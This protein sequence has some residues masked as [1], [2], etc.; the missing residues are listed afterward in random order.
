MKGTLKFVVA[1]AVT[2][3]VMLVFRALV[4]TIYT[5]PSSGLKPELN[6]GDRILVN[7]W[8]YGLRTGLGGLFDYGRLCKGNVEYGD[9]VAFNNPL[10][11]LH[12]ISKRSIFVGYCKAMP[13]D[14]VHF[15]S[16]PE[17][18]IPGKSHM[19][20]VT[21]DNMQLLCNTYIIHEHKDAK[22]KNNNLYVDGKETHCASFTQNYYWM[23]THSNQNLKDSRFFGLV[24]ESHIIGRVVAIVYNKDD[25][26]PFYE[27]YRED[28]LF[29]FI[30]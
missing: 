24:P 6:D 18:I 9:L 1:L 4:F 14:T 26:K 2:F 12:S 23:S 8:S 5:V 22:I 19:V 16:S 28:R 20:R 10:D 29:K 21:K 13:G 17:F 25:S 27:G 7:R 11:S 15:N 30:K 3:L